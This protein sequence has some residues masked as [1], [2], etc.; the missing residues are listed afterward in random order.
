MSY[1]I[2]K[3]PVLWKNFLQSRL[4]DI[5]L[6]EIESVSREEN[7]KVK[8]E[9][10]ELK[11][12]GRIDL[13]IRTKNCYIVIENKIDSGIIMEDGVSQIQRY[14]NYVVWLKKEEKDMLV[15]EIERINKCREKKEEQ[16]KALKNKQGKHGLTWEEELTDL[17]E[18]IKMFNEELLEVEAREFRGFVLSPNYNKPSPEEYEVDGYKYEELLYS[19]I[20]SWLEENAIAELKNDLNFMA[21]HD[22]MKKHTFETPSEALYEEMKNRF[23]SRIQKMTKYFTKSAF[24]IALKCPRRLYYAYDKKTYANQDL[25]DDFLKSLAEGGFQVG[26]FAKLCYGIDAKNTIDTLDADEAIKMTK[27]LFGQENVNIAE[28]AFRS[29]NLFV[30]ADII[31]KQGNIINLIEVKAKSWHPEEESFLAKN[32]KS[33]NNAIRPYLYDVAFQKYVVEKALKEMFPEKTFTVK[34]FLMLADKSRVST[35]NGLNQSFLSCL[36]ISKALQRLCFL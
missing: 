31:E 6:G 12:G 16:Y 24:S 21:F 10:C 17:R 25:D 2:E 7:A 34:A 26:E 22:A 18:Q 3:Y 29:G 4:K 19:N 20:Y 32:G 8:N 5:N 13:L 11:T 33:T 36:T 28:A 35:V 9:T 30:R 1:F 15:N 23:F 27:K 14:Y